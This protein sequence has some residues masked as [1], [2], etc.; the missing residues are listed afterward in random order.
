MASL[1]SRP[2]LSALPAQV[3][4]ATRARAITSRRLST[5]LTP[6]QQ[7]LLLDDS[8]EPALWQCLPDWCKGHKKYNQV[9]ILGESLSARKDR[10]EDKRAPV[11]PGSFASA[12]Q[13]RRRRYT[14]A[15]DPFWGR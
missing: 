12:I 2:L 15:Q 5:L 6:T 3:L 10:L 4:L 8:A 13:R 9:F 14:V 1:V 11:K 7:P